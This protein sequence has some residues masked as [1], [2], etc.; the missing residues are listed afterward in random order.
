MLTSVSQRCHVG[1]TCTVLFRRDARTAEATQAQADADAAAAA[2]AGKGRPTPTRK[3]AEAARKERVKPTMDRR[4]AT[5]A[6]RSATRDQRLKARQA[7]LDGDERALPARDR[8]PVRRFARDYVDSHR[9][10]GELMLPSMVLF[11]PLSL[12]IGALQGSAAGVYVTLTIYL[13]MLLM[14]GGTAMLARRVKSEAKRRFPG[15]DVRGVGMYGSLRS[16]QLRRWRLPR[17]KV[18]VGEPF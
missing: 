3:E 15:E 6:E 2:A 9:T 18:K 5:R 17:P 16:V 12:G 7:L 11:I 14:I 8:G 4:A 10:V 1:I 13:Y